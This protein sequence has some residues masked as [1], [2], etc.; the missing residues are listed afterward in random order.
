[1]PRAALYARVSTAEQAEGHS[2]DAQLERLRGYAREHGFLVAGEYVDP[3]FQ[4]DTDDRPAIKRLLWDT[5]ERKFDFVLVYRFDRLFREVRL[6][7]N[8]EHE[9]RLHGVKLIS[10]TEAIDDT[11]EGRL[12]LLIK[13]SFAEYE[14]AVIRERANLGRLRAAQEGKWMGGPAP[15]GYSLDPQTSRLVIHREE[16]KWVRRFFQWLVQDQLTLHRL[17]RRVN[18]LGIPTKWE[19][20]GRHHHRPVN[21]KGWWKDRT[22]GRILTRQVYTG[23]FYYRRI[24]KPRALKRKDARLR[25]EEEWV[26]IKVPRIIDDRLFH[27]AQLQLKKNSERSPRR[28]DRPYLLRRLIEC[29]TCGRVWI[30]TRNNYDVPYYICSGRRKSVTSERCLRASISAT[31]L[32]PVV[33]ERV[34][35]LLRNP[36]LVLDQIRKRFDQA[37]LSAQK[38]R[39]LRRVSTQLRR[40]EGEEERLIRAYKAGVIHLRTLKLETDET[41]ERLGRLA[42][43]KEQ[44][45][46]ELA[47]WLSKERQLE[48]V[49]CLAHEVLQ[50]LPQLSYEARCGVVQQLVERVIVREKEIEIRTVVPGAP[51]E[52]TRREA[53]SLRD[54]RRVDRP[55]KHPSISNLIPH[56]DPTQAIRIP[57]FAA[58]P[59]PRRSTPHLKKAA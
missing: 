39:D 37:G 30:S 54:K 13:G 56:F 28:Q 26:A 4:G 47:G 10:I 16:A 27:L 35:E 11:H 57:L 48:A 59:P 50:V 14:K 40:A 49:T 21:R 18:D 22:L 15:Y 8:T 29:G 44:L 2:I 24:W 38:E 7:L 3:G 51:S 34:L 23:T 55:A 12:Q 25:P 42:R 36:D 45:E 52:G 41:R 20:L 53:V 58:L 43:K 19:N 1:M 46:A 17:Q 6:F 31:K 32:D 9:F 33:W 5:R